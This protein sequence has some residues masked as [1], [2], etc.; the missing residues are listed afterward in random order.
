MTRLL[1]TADAVGGVWT[2]AIELAGALARRGVHT[3][4]ATMGSPPT[5][6]QLDQARA[7]PHVEVVIGDYE[8]EWADDPW[9]SVDAAGAWLLDLEATLLPALVHLNGYAHGALPWQS[10]VVITAHS[11]V[12]TWAD[13]VGVEI[14][15]RRMERYRNAVAAGLRGAT[16][17][18]APTASMLRSLQRHYGPV[19]RASVIPNGRDPERFYPNAKEPFI[20]TGG[21]LWDRAKNIDALDAVAAALPWPVVAA[22]RRDTAH[23]SGPIHYLGELAEADMADWLGRASIFALPARYEPFGLL[24]LE[25]ALSG[26]ALVLGD[27]DSLHEVWGEAAIYVAPDDHAGLERQLKR[28]IA[29]TTERADYAARAGQRARMYSPDAMAEAYLRTYVDALRTQPLE[30]A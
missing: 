27:I 1:M 11:C 10:P 14:E 2:Y 6:Q 4:I 28:L 22:G 30:P 8:L 25:A 12:T 9:D 19:P 29:D 17:V 26:C 23:H 13:A 24:P 16:H 3:V 5:P 20:C 21:R 15:P 7:I 18:I